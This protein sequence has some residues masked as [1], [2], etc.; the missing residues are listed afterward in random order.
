MDA[1]IKLAKLVRNNEHSVTNAC[2]A[3]ALIGAITFGLSGS[4]SLT[5]CNFLGHTAL[6]FVWLVLGVWVVAWELF[7]HQDDSFFEGKRGR[8]FVAVACPFVIVW[9]VCSV[10]AIVSWPN[11][12]VEAAMWGVRLPAFIIQCVSAFFS[13]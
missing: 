2:V 6:G 4:T 8:R 13:W 3:V 1:L 9:V 11:E 7:Q 12:A 5:D 10:V